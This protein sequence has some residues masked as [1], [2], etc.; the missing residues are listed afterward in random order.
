LLCI[1]GTA[2]GKTPVIYFADQQAGADACAKIVNA[3]TQLPSTGGIVDARGFQGVQSCAGTFA[4]GSTTQAVQLLLGNATF[5]VQNQVGI[6]QG[7]KLKGKQPT[8]PQ[9]P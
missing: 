6:F 7:S 5:I 9:Y 4:I 2:H 3:E 8:E 1:V